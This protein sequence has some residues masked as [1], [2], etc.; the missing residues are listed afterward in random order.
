MNI[1]EFFELFLFLLGTVFGMLAVVWMVGLFTGFM[2]L[3][4]GQTIGSFLGIAFGC[5]LI[6][7]II[8][9]LA[10]INKIYWDKR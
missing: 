8:Y 2:V 4:V 1:K 10:A 9:L 3:F 7:L 5:F 6:A